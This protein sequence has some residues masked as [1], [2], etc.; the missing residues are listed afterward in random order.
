[1]LI[2]LLIAM[3]YLYHAVNAYVALDITVVASLYVFTA[4]R[5]NSWISAMRRDY[6]QKEREENQILQESIQN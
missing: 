2:D 1:M 4:L 6:S 3:I 5:G